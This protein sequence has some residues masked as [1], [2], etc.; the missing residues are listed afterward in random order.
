MTRTV[1]L[2]VSSLLVVLLI[3][4][5]VATMP[6]A[7]AHPQFDAGRTAQL[8]I[9]KTASS[10]D[11]AQEPLAGVVFGIQKVNGIDLNS[12]EGWK[13]LST[14]DARDVQ[15]HPERLG[16]LTHAASRMVDATTAAAVFSDLPLGVYLVTEQPAR[17]GD[18]SY[19]VV[20]PFLVPLPMNTSDGWNYDVV[21]QAKNQPISITKTASATNVQS[22]DDITYTLNSTIPAP[23]TQ[24]KLYRYIVTDPLPSA[25]AYRSAELAL[26]GFDGAPQLRADT[27]YTVRYDAA[28]R[29]VTL[30]VTEAGLRTLADARAHNAAAHVRASI[31]VTAVGNPGDPIDN[32]AAFFP[33]GY[34]PATSKGIS[35]NTHRI[36]IADHKPPVDGSGNSSGGAASGGS[37]AGASGGGPAS[38]GTSADT[39]TSWLQRR[40]VLRQGQLAL[41]GAGI[42]GLCIA[43]AT[44]LFA[45]AALMYYRDRKQRKAKR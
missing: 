13:E 24:G 4:L 12:N 21:V 29:E 5:G 2:L 37:A 14:L 1:E 40:G 6:A 17:I 39:P 19:S 25:V 36:V 9:H 11:T 26:T 43:G 7:D 32:T 8:S 20:A 34:D 42:Y 41:T 45:G 22:G 35:S 33:D 28:S 18:V 30:T 3:V 15:Q 27:D 10:T 23:D 31:R 38:N 16:E 44:A